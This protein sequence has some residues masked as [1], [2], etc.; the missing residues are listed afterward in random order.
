MEIN[1]SRLHSLI[2]SLLVRATVSAEMRALA[3]RVWLVNP[4]AAMSRFTLLL[5]MNYSVFHD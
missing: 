1:V 3:A 4:L 2:L 5:I